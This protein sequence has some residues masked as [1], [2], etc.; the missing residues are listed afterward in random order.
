MTVELFCAMCGKLKTLGLNMREITPRY[1]VR[2]IVEDAGWIAQMNQP[3]LD[4]YC[5]RKCAE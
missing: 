4:I 3:N 2:Q 5:S 1:T